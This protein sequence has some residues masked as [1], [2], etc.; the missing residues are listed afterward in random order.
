MRN[1]Y[2]IDQFEVLHNVFY[3]I[4]NESKQQIQ[5]QAAGQV[6]VDSEDAAF[7]YIVE[8]DGVYSYLRFTENMWPQL[9]EIVKAECDP[10]LRV[11]DGQIQLTNFFEELHMLLFN[12]EGND[13]YGETFVTSVEKV[14]AEILLTNEV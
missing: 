11:A 13:N 4:L 2:T 9:V 3:F 10:F 14:F 1:V 7:I 8:E 6:I 5:M 12:I